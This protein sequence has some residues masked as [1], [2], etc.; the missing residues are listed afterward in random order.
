MRDT[1]EQRLK[2]GS[3]GW[4]QI[5]ALVFATT[6]PLI[7]LV[8]AVPVALTQGNGIGMAGC[9]LLAGLVY[10][11][12]GA[13]F[14]ALTR[15][16]A[17]AGAFYACVAR[18][19][20]RPAGLI[21]AGLATTAYMALQLCCYGL[22][23]FF[24]AQLSQDVWGEGLPW[25]FNAL[26]VNAVVPFC[27]QRN[28]AFAA[29][30]LG[31]LV[32]AE[33]VVLAAFA[34]SV[35][36]HGGGPE[37]LSAQPFAPAQVFSAGFGAAMVFAVA[38]FAGFETA[39][40][41]GEEARAPQRTVPRV[42]LVAIL[43][44]TATLAGS[45]W[46]L[47]AAYGPGEVVDA[48]AR[49]PGAL[50][51]SAVSR[52]LSPDLSTAMAVLLM[53]SLFASIVGLQNAVSRYLYALGRDGAIWPVLA[54]MHPQHE[55]PYIA[56]LAQA[57]VSILALAGLGLVENDPLRI[58]LGSASALA[59]I[60]LLSAQI[61]VSA[62]VIGFFRG[63][64]G[65]VWSTRIAPAASALALSALL[66]TVLLNLPSLTG[67]SA[68]AAWTIA[69]ALLALAGACALRAWTMKRRDPAAY[70]RLGGAR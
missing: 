11:V 42:L 3:V 17:D 2:A 32:L 46:A 61:L 67:G 60:A 13:G 14:A 27:A 28:L 69:I 25:W 50:W 47:I 5:L 19:L 66:C 18:G 22:I 39:A 44:V 54:Q 51:F 53:T 9:F 16:V 8:G 63:R 34:A 62:A 57:S 15:Q 1:P 7:G 26:L 37:G 64:G 48:A 43:A 41:Y 70:A 10:L 55:T 38:A 65:G 30:L 49:D 58:A 20:S 23:G 35:L 40:V 45:A 21:A 56:N 4:L 33:F 24:M 29:R 52:F 68:A 36:W 12:F 31:V 6:G 59:V